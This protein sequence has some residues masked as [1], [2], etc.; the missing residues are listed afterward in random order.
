MAEAHHLLSGGKRIGHEATIPLCPE[1][2]W[3][4]HN[5]KKSFHDKHGTDEYLLDLTNRAVANFESRTV[6]G[7]V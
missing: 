5:E 7:E 1:C 6:G 3:R 2:H 4:I